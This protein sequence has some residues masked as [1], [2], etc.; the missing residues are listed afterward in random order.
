MSLFNILGSLFGLGAG[1]AQSATNRRTA[2]ETNETNARIAHETN[3]YNA[4]AVADT[5]ASNERM[6]DANNA[7]QMQLAQDANDLN[8]RMF[9]EQNDW[10]LNMWN[11]QNEYNDPSQQMARLVAAGVNPN[12]ALGS[13]GASV[14]GNS[15]N[16]P[17]S[18]AW[19]GANVADVNPIMAQSPHH[20]PWKAIPENIDFLPAMMQAA[21]I[22]NTE[23]QTEN[24]RMRTKFE[25]QN[26]NTIAEMRMAQTQYIAEQLRDFLDAG[27]YRKGTRSLDLIGRR[28][29][30]DL[31]KTSDEQMKQ[32][33]QQR[34]D[35]FAEW[36][37]LSPVRKKQFIADLAETYKRIEHMSAEE[38]QMKAEARH[39]AVS[40]AND[41]SRIA[42]ARQAL[43][44]T[45]L[46]Y[47]MKSYGLKPETR[48]TLAAGLTESGLTDLGNLIG[49]LDGAA[50]GN[51]N[52]IIS[53]FL[54]TQFGS[55]LEKVMDKWLTDK[56]DDL[57]EDKHSNPIPETPILNALGF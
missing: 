20:D 32:E 36:K 46:D 5:N 4:Q 22:A 31:R 26:Y 42:L 25:P 19:A 15:D 17:S 33:I 30:N 40:D 49:S 16:M 8:Y 53:A 37:E 1:I 54:H 50:D 23:A 21:G 47:A 18:A 2:H 39:W 28:L 41:A 45:A 9:Q 44:Y 3:E 57:T 24:M 55:K 7:L 43:T 10:N 51:Y 13:N 35:M 12:M 11:L 14:A 48:K 34:K 6:N 52:T 29:I 27:D 38:I 56:L